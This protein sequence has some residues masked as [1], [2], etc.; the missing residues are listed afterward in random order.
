MLRESDSAEK[1]MGIL[2]N[3]NADNCFKL[4]KNAA[5]KVGI[6]KTGEFEIN[7]HMVSDLLPT[8]TSIIRRIARKEHSILRTCYERKFLLLS[9]AYFMDAE[10]GLWWGSSSSGDELF[11]IFYYSDTDTVLI[12]NFKSFIEVSTSELFVM[13]ASF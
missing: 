9:H 5:F 1:L 3:L 4:L 7:F 11:E 12:H 2:L 8:L 10:E 6:I 13:S